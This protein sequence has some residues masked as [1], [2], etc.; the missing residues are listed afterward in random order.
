M[1][2]CVA[3]MCN[4]HTILGASDRMITAGDVQFQPPQPKI[5]QLTSSIVAMIAGDTA[6]QTEILIE[7]TAEVTR[8]VQANPQDWLNVK[9]VAEL[10]SQFYSDI[11]RKKA[12]KRILHPLG[13][14]SNTYIS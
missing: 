7:L 4:V 6:L 9:D 10:Y 5:W 12:E 14:D 2:I 13:L 11:H 8:R 3:A 1:T